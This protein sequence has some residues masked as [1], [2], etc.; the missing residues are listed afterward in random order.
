MGADMV[1]VVV[2][3]VVEVVL[4]VHLR[5]ARTTYTKESNSTLIHT[6]LSDKS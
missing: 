5:S 2:V 3:V 1:V 6:L 4:L